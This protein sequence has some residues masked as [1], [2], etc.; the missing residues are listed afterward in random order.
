VDDA[1]AMAA[2]HIDSI[3]SIGPRFYAGDVVQAWRAGVQ[4][5][6]YP[7]AMAG[8][9]TFFVAVTSQDSGREVLGFS[10]SHRLDDRQHGVGV[11]VRGIAARRGIGTALL[12]MAESSAA[13]AGAT[14]LQL[15]SSLAAVDFYKG[16]ASISSDRDAAWS[17]SSCTRI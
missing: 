7:A 2:A 3:E 14:S 16:E 12:R 15:D 9:E 13:A 10:A 8:G 11:Y 4:P 17:A 5:D 6:I 1:S